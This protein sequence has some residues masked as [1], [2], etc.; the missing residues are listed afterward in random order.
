MTWL[1]TGGSGFLGVHLLRRLSADGVATRSLDLV[2]LDIELP[3]VESW[4]GDIRDPGLVGAALEGVEVVVHAAAALPAGSELADVNTAATASLAERARAVGVRRSLF[5]SSAVVY[6]LLEPPVPETAEP[7][8]VERYGR[9]KLAAEAAWSAVAPGAVVL[10]PSAF[11]GPERLGAFGLL[12][13]WVAEGRRIYVLGNG[14]HRYQLLDVDDLVTAIVRAARW[15]G[16]G[17]FNVGGIVG[18]TVRGELEALIAHAGS[19]SRVVGVPVRPAQATLWT[20]E[21]LRLSPLQEWHRLSAAHDFVLDCRRARESLCWT[22]E[23]SGA[24][25]LIRAFD[26]YR[27]ADATRPYGVTHRTVWR[28]RALGLLRRVS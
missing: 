11:V 14:A 9:S 16:N 28:E 10:R 6:G 21:R 20:L 12:F 27:S 17:V 19:R 26:W 3:G 18:G 7:R 15:S 4:V 22:P 1:V 13:R 24:D 25:A 5:V 23:R 2:P 8:P